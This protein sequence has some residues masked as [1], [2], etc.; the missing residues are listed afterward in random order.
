MNSQR[1]EFLSDKN[2]FV[3]RWKMAKEHFNHV[4]IIPLKLDSATAEVLTRVS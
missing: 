1:L 3:E 4:L 2:E